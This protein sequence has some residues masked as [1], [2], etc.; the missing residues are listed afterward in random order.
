MVKHNEER[1]LRVSQVAAAAVSRAVVQERRDDRR[2]VL[3]LCSTFLPRYLT[4]IFFEGQLIWFLLEMGE[5]TICT[6]FQ[7]VINKSVKN[8][9]A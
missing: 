8:F 4:S 3:T 7:S 9:F 5:S 1:I 6:S 2:K